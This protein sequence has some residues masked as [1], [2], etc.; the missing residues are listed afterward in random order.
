MKSKIRVLFES[1]ISCGK[2]SKGNDKDHQEPI[3][4]YESPRNAQG[5]DQDE[6]KHTHSQQGVLLGK[7]ESENA[8][9]LGQA[10]QIMVKIEEEYAKVEQ[11]ERVFVMEHKAKITTHQKITTHSRQARLSR[12]LS[13]PEFQTDSRD[14]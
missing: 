6:P 11:V 10:G 8:Q 2:P 14:L 3:P 9:L 12:Q 7:D 4:I 5:H 13:S 1:L